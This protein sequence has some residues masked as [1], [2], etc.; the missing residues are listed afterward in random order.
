MIYLLKL[1][2]TSVTRLNPFPQSPPS[3]FSPFG[4]FLCPSESSFTQ[5]LFCP[6]CK[7]QT[8]RIQRKMKN[9]KSLTCT[10]E[11]LKNAGILDA[12]ET[13]SIYAAAELLSEHYFIG[14]HSNPEKIDSHPKSRHKKAHRSDY[15]KNVYLELFFKHFKKRKMTQLFDEIILKNNIAA[16]Q[17]LKKK[18]TLKEEFIHFLKD[19]HLDLMAHIE[20]KSQGA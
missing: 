4:H 12:E 7:A 8:K 6:L 13:D 1:L 16:L 11:L 10:I 5:I 20:T 19:L 3:S 15:E 9:D 17:L 14:S 18:P 2:P